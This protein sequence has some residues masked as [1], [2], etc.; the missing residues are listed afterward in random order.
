VQSRRA[1]RRIKSGRHRSE[2]LH[3]TRDNSTVD[4]AGSKP[5]RNATLS[6]RE[7]IAHNV[8][9]R[10]V[11]IEENRPPSLIDTNTCSR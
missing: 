6:I 4:R 3:R 2:S 5:C 9:Q 1:G 8:E 7:L 10:A 11:D